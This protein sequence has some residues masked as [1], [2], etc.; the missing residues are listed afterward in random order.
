M[1]LLLSGETNWNLWPPLILTRKYTI[2]LG[3][4]FCTD[5]NQEIYD[6]L[7]YNFTFW[8]EERDDQTLFWYQIAQEVGIRVYCY[9]TSHLPVQEKTPVWPDLDCMLQVRFDS[10]AI[11]A[12]SGEKILEKKWVIIYL[13]IWVFSRSMGN[14]SSVGQIFQQQMPNISKKCSVQ[15]QIYN[16]YDE[17]LMMRNIDTFNLVSL[18]FFW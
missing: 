18:D 2:S 12:K 7:C 17:I 15:R 4:L 5:Q 3:A 6:T 8:K 16:C 9:W 11:L 10:F 14:E 13:L 1:A